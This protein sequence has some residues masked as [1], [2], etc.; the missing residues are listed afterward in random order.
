MQ[1]ATAGLVEA[2]EAGNAEAVGAAMQAVR[3]TCA[4]CH[5]TFR[6]PAGQ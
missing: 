3:G 6:G 2:A 4:G 5:Q 1:T